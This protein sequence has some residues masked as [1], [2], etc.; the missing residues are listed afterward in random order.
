MREYKY[1][2]SAMD[3]AMLQGGNSCFDE[4][5]TKVGAVVIYGAC[6]RDCQENIWDFPFM[7][8]MD[9]PDDFHTIAC[10]YAC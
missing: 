9:I 1:A 10:V 4:S 8:Q 5:L 2:I 7:I 6:T 3:I